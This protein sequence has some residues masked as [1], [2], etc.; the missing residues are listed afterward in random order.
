MSAST[1]PNPTKEVAIPAVPAKE[2]TPFR[3]FARQFL[4][5]KLAVLGLVTLG[6]IILIAIF[7]PW[8]A[9]QNPYDLATLDVLDARMAPGEQAGSGLT[10]LLGSDEQGRDILSAVMY[11]LR[12]SIGVGVL[13]TVIALLLGATLG[14]LAGFL[15]GRIEALIM[16]VADLQLSFPPILLALILLAFLRPGLGN[17]VIALVAVQWAYYAR[18]TRSAALVERRKEYIEAATCL[19]LPPGRIMFRHLLPNCLPPLI[20]IAALQVA[21]A[22]TLEAT[23]SF[24]GLGVPVTEPSLG[25][26][27]SNGQ[28]YMLSGKYWISFFP[29]IAL[30]VTIVSMNLVADQLR[31]VLNPRLQTQ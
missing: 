11:G 10:F 5:S 23:L 18:T 22:I 30:V 15:G 27:I 6:L 9:P 25:S 12:I 16:R 13:S 3:R 20:V 31:D 2:Q 1:V 7:A 26:L 17:I 14:L 4:E 19:G 8:L 24:L 21:S 28:Q 29:G